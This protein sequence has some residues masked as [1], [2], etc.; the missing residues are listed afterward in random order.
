MD[1]LLSIALTLAAVVT[2]TFFMMHAVPGGPF[3]QDKE[4]PPEVLKA[5]EAK[6]HLD[7]PLYLQYINYVKGLLVWDLGPSFQKIGVSVNDIIK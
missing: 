2:L 4:V 5:L 6:Y 7:E 3:A 1:R